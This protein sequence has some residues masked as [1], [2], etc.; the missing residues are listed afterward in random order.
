MAGQPTVS[1]A[2]ARRRPAPDRPARSALAVQQRST[3][4]QDAPRTARSCRRSSKRRRHPPAAG[5]ARGDRA[6]ADTKAIAGS[7]EGRFI[8]STDDAYVKADMS[9]LAAKVSGYVAAVPIVENAAV[10]KGQVLATIDD[11]DYRNAVDAARARIETQAATIDRIGKQIGAQSAAIDQ[12]KAMVQSAKADATRAPRRSSSVPRSLMQQLLRHAAEARSGP[13]RSGPERRGRGQRHRGRHGRPG[14]HGRAAGPEDRGPEG[15]GRV[16]DRARQSQPRPVLHGH[17]GAL[18]RRGRQQGGPARAICA[19]RHAP[20]VAGAARERLC[21]GQLQGNPDR[22]AEARPE[23][24]DQ[25]RCLRRAATRR[26]HRREHRAGLGRRILAAAARERDRQLHQ[27][28]AAPAGAHR[29]SRPMWR[30]RAFCGPASRSWSTCIRAT[31]ASRSLRCSSALG[32]DAL[33]ARRSQPAPVAQSGTDP[34][35]RCRAGSRAARRLP[36]VQ[37][38]PRRPQSAA[39]SGHSTRAS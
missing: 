22:P 6:A 15:A 4:P 11:G 16:A 37:H 14:R 38:R 3:P 27:D 13:R 34:R 10:S 12:A 1:D 23:G 8:V 33:A 36:R 9:T 7:S 18:R 21:R 32:L 24:R 28:R 17:P 29:G 5:A 20:A 30:A 39:A 2:T 25:A 31:K 35:G 26:R 19:A